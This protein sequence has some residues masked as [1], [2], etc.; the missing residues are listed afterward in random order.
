MIILL[1]TVS[2]AAGGLATRVVETSSLHPVGN[3]GEERKTFSIKKLRTG[4]ICKVWLQKAHHS[5][6]LVSTHPFQTPSEANMGDFDYDNINFN[7]NPLYGASSVPI[8]SF[9]EFFNYPYE[10]L[11]EFRTQKYRKYEESP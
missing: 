1:K 5:C 10:T 11:K 3:S 6:L 8:Q 7:G 4:E 2:R 9:T